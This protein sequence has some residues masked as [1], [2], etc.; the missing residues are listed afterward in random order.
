MI[1]RHYPIRTDEELG[2]KP[3]A[4]DHSAKWRNYSV[5]LFIF[6]RHDTHHWLDNALQDFVE[7]WRDNSS[8]RVTNKRELSHYNRALTFR[9]KTTPRSSHFYERLKME[10]HHPCFPFWKLSPIFHLY[11]WIS[12]YSTYRWMWFVSL[13][14]VVGADP[15]T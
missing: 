3:S 7:Y 6:C 11:N 1:N 8:Y 4:L 10:L 5:S 12:Y 9:C 13:I 2:P 14:G 15:T